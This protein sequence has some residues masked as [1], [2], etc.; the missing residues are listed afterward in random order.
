MQKGMKRERSVTVL[1]L[2]EVV[3]VF[4]NSLKIFARRMQHYNW[5]RGGR[6]STAADFSMA[7]QSAAL[8]AD[9]TKWYTIRAQRAVRQ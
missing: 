4:V 6:K 7:A 2:L 9:Q 5:N 8:Y 3:F 1:R